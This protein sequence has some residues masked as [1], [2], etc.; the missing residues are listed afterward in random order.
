LI[1]AG[2]LGETWSANT[3]FDMANPF[4]RC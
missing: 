3:L 1:A 2:M 4:E